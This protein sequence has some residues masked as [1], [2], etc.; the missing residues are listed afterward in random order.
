MRTV[1]VNDQNITLFIGE[2]L[3]NDAEQIAIDFSPW[4]EKY[5]DGTIK[6]RMKRPGVLAYEVSSLVVDGSTAI[7]TPSE[8][9]TGEKGNCEVEV[10][11]YAGNVRAM[12]VVWRAVVTKSLVEIGPAP[13]PY[14]DIV[15]QVREYAE[16]AEASAQ[17]AE[18]VMDDIDFE[19]VNGHLIYTHGA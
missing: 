15:E 10:F 17:R 13:D 19:I 4:I 1:N 9:D 12:S 3:E 5:G 7:W 11:Y 2:K 6:V 8:I 14:Q 18:Q 16:S